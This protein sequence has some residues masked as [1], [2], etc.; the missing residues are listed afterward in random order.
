MLRPTKEVTLT[1][2]HHVLFIG[3]V[4]DYTFPSND[5]FYVFNNSQVTRIGPYELT[6]S[7]TLNDYNAAFY[8]WFAE[9]FQPPGR[10]EELRQVFKID[11]DQIGKSCLVINMALMK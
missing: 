4:S 8:E 6:Y 7:L 2:K 5:S 11:P 9:Y 3:F 1:K 10:F